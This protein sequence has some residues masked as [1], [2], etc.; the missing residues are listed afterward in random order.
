[1]EFEHFDLGRSLLALTAT[2][3]LPAL[4]EHTEQIPDVKGKLETAWH[5]PLF[6]HRLLAR[7]LAR[8]VIMPT[9]SV[10]CQNIVG[11][12]DFLELL[13]V[14]ALI[15][16]MGLGELSKGPFYFLAVRFSIDTEYL[17]GIH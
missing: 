3:R 17:V 1:M 11:Q 16:V 10:I 7:N 12:S 13:L 14:A 4:P 8:H 15:G 2:T 5:P 6:G 9:L